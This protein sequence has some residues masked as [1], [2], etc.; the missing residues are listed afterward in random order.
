MLAVITVIGILVALLLP[1]VQAA[2]EAARRVSCSNNLAQIILAVQQ[3]ESLH[4]VYPP[5]TIDV[6]GPILH[7]PS[8]Y[9]HNWISQILPFL[10]HQPLARHIDYQV[11]V[12]DMA[13]RLPRE[14]NLEIFRC[15]SSPA[16]GSGYS[17]YAGIHNDREVPIDVDNNG[18]FFL[19]SRVRYDDVVDGVSNTLFVGEKATIAG[20]LGWMSGTR[21]TL[22]NLGSLNAG[23]RRLPWASGFPPGVEYADATRALSPDALE[24]ILFPSDA[25]SW[26]NVPPELQA[27][28]PENMNLAV[29]GV[30]SQHPGGCQFAH[31]DGSVRFLSQAVDVIARHQ[32]GS[33][34]D[35]SL[36]GD[37]SW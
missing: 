2:R 22:R 32:L 23:G 31:G 19:N 12:Y 8:G 14:V 29:G 26:R 30:A 18:I 9:H 36:P 27:V 35:R 20:D 24:A 16:S 28:P 7:V 6:Q 4:Q 37:D 34:A 21:A 33:R 3:Y 15:P 25:S 1:A 5:G 10:E 13:N 11:S 17:D